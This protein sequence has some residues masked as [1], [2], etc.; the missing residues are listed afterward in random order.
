MSSPDP[1]L[2]PPAT[3]CGVWDVPGTGPDTHGHVVWEEAG[4]AP[5]VRMYR[6]DFV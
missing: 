5:A 2:H 1:T 6:E 4:A 3:W